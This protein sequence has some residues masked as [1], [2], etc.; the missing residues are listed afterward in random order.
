[1]P[2]A[3][4]LGQIPEAQSCREDAYA[5]GP[6]RQRP[7]FISITAGK[8]H[9]VNV[10]DEI[11]PEAGAKAIYTYDLGDTWEHGIILEK[12][13]AADPNTAYPVCTGGQLACP[14]EDCGGVGGF[15]D[16]LDAISNPNHDQHEELRDWVGD[17]FDPKAFS[18]DDVNRKL[19]PFHRRKDMGLRRAKH[20]GAP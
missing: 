10:L 9:D 18:V 20:T 11:L 17:D 3:V 7:T 4:S 19:S 14:P 8:V 13:V 6:A 15:Y 16:L 5:A 1:V 2:F 12:R